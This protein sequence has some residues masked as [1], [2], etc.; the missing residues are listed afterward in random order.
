M[1]LSL[2]F[3]SLKC[4]T[5]RCVSDSYSTSGLVSKLILTSKNTETGA[6]SSRGLF[7]VAKHVI[8]HTNDLKCSAFETQGHMCF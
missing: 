3:R 4:L 8:I 7:R 1:I 5:E 6:K 2:I